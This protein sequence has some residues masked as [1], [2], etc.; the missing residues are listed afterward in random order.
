MRPLSVMLEKLMQSGEFLRNERKQMSLIFKKCKEKDVGN[1]RP[2]SIISIPG[3]VME[4]II[5]ESVSKY[6]KV[7]KV[8][9]SHQHG[10]NEG[11][12]MQEQPD[13]PLQCERWLSG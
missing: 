5:L 10:F 7:K 4:E 13:S 11:E 1:Y 12:I 8:T 3:K 2:V 6:I 9:R